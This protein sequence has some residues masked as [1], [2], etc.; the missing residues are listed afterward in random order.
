M[1]L[2]TIK[3][4]ER[5]KADRLPIRKIARKSALRLILI[6][7][8]EFVFEITVY[9]PR[10]HRNVAVLRQRF[11]LLDEPFDCLNLRLGML[12]LQLGELDEILAE[13][14]HAPCLEVIQF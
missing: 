7:E 10:R 9:S 2:H 13:H 12:D 5:F 6:K 8:S 11:G 3:K 1:L 14:L 4:S